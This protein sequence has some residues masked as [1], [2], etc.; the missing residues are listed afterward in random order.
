MRV[1]KLW[2]TIGALGVGALVATACPGPAGPEPT[3]DGSGSEPV[4]A[5]DY[6]WSDPNLR[7]AISMAIDRQSI[8]DVI[9][10]G[11][12][13]PADDFWP[14][15]IGGYRGAGSC[16]NLE[17]NPEEALTLFEE[18][19]G[20]KGTLRLWFNSGAGHEDWVEAVS[21]QLQ[22]NLLIEDI[23]FEALEFAPYL[24]ALDQ[25]QV[26]GPFRLGWLMDY[27]SAENFLRPLHG[28]GGSSNHTGYSNPDFDALVAQ[29]DAAGIE[30]G[31]PFYQDAADI[32]CADMPIA[33]MF[34]GLL[35][36]VHSAN[37][38]NV[39]FDAFQA[40][41]VEQVEDVAGDGITMYICE[42]Q[43]ALFGQNSNETCG[44]EVVRGL[45]TGLVTLGDDGQTLEYDAVAESITS[46]DD[47]TWTITLKP[48]W[49]FHDG[50]A[51]DAAS[52]LRAWNWA[53][54]A[55]N[56]AANNFFFSSIDGYEAMNPPDANEDGTPDSE[57]TATE[58]TGLTL[59]DDLT[60]T[61]TLSTAFPLFP[62]QLLYNAFNPLPAAFADPATFGD[63]PIGNGP[64]MF[65][66][67]GAWEHNV[68]VAL[69]RYDGYGG[70][71]PSAASITYKIYSADTTGYND[72]R[73]GALDIMD[74]VPI[75]EIEAAKTEFGERYF[76]EP[77]ASFNY[78]GFPIDPQ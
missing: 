20:D 55:P 69:V 1:P 2:R 35:Q 36:G 8:T 59:V 29:G 11:A 77:T 43:T 40:L 16:P 32:L 9:F 72:V 68:Q 63:A 7:R 42:P 66:E 13:A 47:T 39:E 52:F 44:S 37:V 49:T 71:A 65:P 64:F 14:S 25:G 3:P 41:E 4:Q 17:Y 28:T 75:A 27:P 60:F 61:V 19:G 18:S 30:D 12:R 15:I 73:S 51:V 78:L 10:Q 54:L 34:F 26:D 5:G 62:L 56:G 23:E 76:E 33:P 21:N 6:D 24:D 45:F 46:E 58:L 57:P 50:T 53:A 38:A 70:T 31:I 67:G 22:E 74:T 48:D